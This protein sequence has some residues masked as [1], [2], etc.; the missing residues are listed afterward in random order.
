MH[1]GYRRARMPTTG[2]CEDLRQYL[3]VLPSIRCTAELATA[4]VVGEVRQS[5]R[6]LAAVG[7]AGDARFAN[8]AI[9]Q[10][11]VDDSPYS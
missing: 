1:A 3:G 7:L 8:V 9:D 6:R 10:G 2:F 5:L 11:P 4:D